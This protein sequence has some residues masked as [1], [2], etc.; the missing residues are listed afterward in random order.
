LDQLLITINDIKAYSDLSPIVKEAEMQ[1]YVRQAQRS[2]L[3]PILC[4]DTYNALLAGSTQE[5]YLSLMPYIVPFLVFATI[6]IYVP[7]SRMKHGPAGFK[8]IEDVNSSQASDSMIQDYVSQ[9]E[10][11]ELQAKG[12]LLNYLEENKTLFPAWEISDC[13]CLPKNA[14]TNFGFIGRNT[15]DTGDNFIWINR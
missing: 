9:Y 4:K 10:Q 7:Q 14:L 2:R 6:R 12:E 5:P 8:I 1:P 13:R 15:D 11:M 3:L